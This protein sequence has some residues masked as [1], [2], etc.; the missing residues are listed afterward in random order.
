MSSVV[1]GRPWKNLLFRDSLSVG[2]TCTSQ[3]S[4]TEHVGKLTGGRPQQEKEIWTTQG[5][6]FI[7]LPLMLSENLEFPTKSVCS[8][9][10][11]LF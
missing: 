11:S 8:I 1:L 4:G 6:K 5:K 2:M 3:E 10:I 7:F 9:F